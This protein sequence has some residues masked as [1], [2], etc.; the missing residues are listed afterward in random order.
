MC[1]IHG[2]NGV[3]HDFVPQTDGT[4]IRFRARSNKFSCMVPPY[5]R[6]VRASAS[7]DFYV[8]WWVT[9][10]RRNEISFIYFYFW[11]VDISY[12]PGVFSGCNPGMGSYR[13]VDC[14]DY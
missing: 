1:C 7:F 6:C 14:H 12:S 9:G 5:C 2:V 11:A 13:C 10:C 3:S 4:S 8:S